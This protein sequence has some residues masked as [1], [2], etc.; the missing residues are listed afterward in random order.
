[1][2]NTLDHG[3]YTLIARGFNHLYGLLLTVGSREL[4]GWSQLLGSCSR[5]ALKALFSRCKGEVL[6]EGEMLFETVRQTRNHKYIIGCPAVG[7]CC[8]GNPETQWGESR[9]WLSDRVIVYCWLPLIVT[10]MPRHAIPCHKANFIL[11]YLQY[12]AALLGHH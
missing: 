9:M 6:L 7:L 5:P 10:Q 12:R 3:S 11:H 4:L 8:C 2:R 1:M